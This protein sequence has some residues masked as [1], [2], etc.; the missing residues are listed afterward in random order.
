MASITFSVEFSELS[1]MELDSVE[2]KFR[3]VIEDNTT[4]LPGSITDLS[5]TDR[6]EDEEDNGDNGED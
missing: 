4:K 3:K 1:N 2:K 5:E 6:Q